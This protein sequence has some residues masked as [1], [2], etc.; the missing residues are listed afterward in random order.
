MRT[1]WLLLSLPFSGINE[2][3]SVCSTEISLWQV[4]AEVVAKFPVVDLHEVRLNHR[5]LLNA[6]WTWAGVKRKDRGNIAQVG[7]L[8]SQT[9]Y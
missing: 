2:G 8:S 7:T 4:A 3:L 9:G 6:I 1:T 5:H